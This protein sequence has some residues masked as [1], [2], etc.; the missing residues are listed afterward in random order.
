MISLHNPLFILLAVISYFTS[1]IITQLL[2][3]H[4][5]SLLFLVVNHFVIRWHP[6]QQDNKGLM[7]LD[8]ADHMDRMGRMDRVGHVGVKQIDHMVRVE[9]GVCLVKYYGLVFC[10]LLA[11]LILSC[12]DFLGGEGSALFKH[13]FDDIPGFWRRDFA[14]Q[15][16]LKPRRRLF[17]SHCRHRL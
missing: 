14:L 16:L 3:N 2:L 12:E 8:H 4:Q 5:D 6:A 17:Y 11:V 15:C 7:V 1:S 13:E 9:G 10:R